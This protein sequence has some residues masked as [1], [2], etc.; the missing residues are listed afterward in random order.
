MDGYVSSIYAWVV[1]VVVYLLERNDMAR[2]VACV[3]YLHAYVRTAVYRHTH[4]QNYPG[5]LDKPFIN[6]KRPYLQHKYSA[7]WPIDIARG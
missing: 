7:A 3:L 5:E 4:T 2:G 6:Q 1:V